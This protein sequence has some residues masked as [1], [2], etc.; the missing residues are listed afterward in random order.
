MEIDEIVE[1]CLQNDSRAYEELFEKTAPYFMGLCRRYITSSA[2][3]EDVLQ[4]AFIK[5]FQSLSSLREVSLF[6]AWAKRIV[7]NMAIGFL[8]KKSVLNECVDADVGTIELSESEVSES[9]KKLR[10]MEMNEIVR[11]MDGLPEGYKTVLNLYSIEGYSHK[12]I[13][14]ILGISEGA[15]RSQYHKAKKAFQKVILSNQSELYPDE[16]L[17]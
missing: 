9:E 6:Q 14:E 13:A 3:A 4:E 5:I 16:R 1:K 15:S 8:R 7:I 17:V 10:T 2:D 12:E 11:L